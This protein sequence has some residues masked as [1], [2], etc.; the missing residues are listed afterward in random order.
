M[1][2]KAARLA[3]AGRI[4]ARDA[5]EIG[6]AV[7]P[8]DY[9]PLALRLGYVLRRAQLAVFQ[10]FI[11]AFA[12]HD[13]QPAQYSVLTVIEH[14]P[15]LSQ[16]QVAQALGIKKPNLVAMIDAL[17]ARG[18]VLRLP[19]PRD[20]R[21]HALTMTRQGAVL[22]RTL[23]RLSGEHEARVMARLGGAY[24][25]IYQPLGALASLGDGEA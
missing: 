21:S 24:A 14:N 1:P 2:T 16:T 5:Q 22:M 8:I 17:E 23:H 19:T 13:V 10:D 18:L 11:A 7:R 9:G 20:R 4:E 15:G 6:G 3:V 25:A 12:A